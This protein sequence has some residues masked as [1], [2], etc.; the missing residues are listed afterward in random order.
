MTLPV[1]PG[2]LHRDGAAPARGEPVRE[3]KQ[4][5][6]R[7]GEG[8]DVAA[9]PRPLLHAGTRDHRLL[10]HVQRSTARVETLHHRPPP[11]CPAAGWSREVEVYETCSRVRT[12]GD[13]PGG[14]HGSRSNFTAACSTPLGTTTSVPPRRRRNPT[15]QFHP[16]GSRPA[17]GMSNFTEWRTK[18]VFALDAY[19]GVP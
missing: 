4:A 8:R 11:D 9:D 19:Q 13:S 5:G 18:G 17:T 7:R 16:S 14:S 12:R 2:C 3:R 6:R 1:P 10:V 15:S